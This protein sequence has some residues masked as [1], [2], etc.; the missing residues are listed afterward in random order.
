MTVMDPNDDPPARGPRAGLQP[1]P[2]PVVELA[3]VPALSEEQVEAFGAFYVAHVARVVTFLRFQGASCVEA[4]DAA[5]EAMT[6]T[7]ERW[8]TLIRPDAWVRKVASREFIRRRVSD[9][10]D[11]TDQ[12]PEPTTGLLRDPTASAAE[13]QEE[14]REVQRRLATLPARQRQVLAWTYDGY[15]PAEIAD[16]LST[17]TQTVTAEAVRSSLKLAR[18]ALTQQLGLG[19]VQP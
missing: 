3:Q 19:E 2:P 10:E 7:Y 9:R 6:R 15:S 11:S 17:L 1:E 5:Q 18:R 4:A 8:E 14:V 16:Q 12:V 13:D